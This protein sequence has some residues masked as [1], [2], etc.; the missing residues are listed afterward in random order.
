M[1]LK[2]VFQTVFSIF[3][4]ITYLIFLKIINL[5]GLFKEKIFFIN[6]IL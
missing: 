2:S 4:V 1:F 3:S 6:K 5:T